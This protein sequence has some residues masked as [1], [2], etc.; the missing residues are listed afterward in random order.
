MGA[1]LGFG[2]R[3][4]GEPALRFSHLTAE[5]RVNPALEPGRLFPDLELTD[6]SGNRR[7]LSALAAGDPLV[8][9]CYRGWFCPKERAFFARLCQF[10]QELEVAYSRLVSVS[11]EPP[12]V[13]AAFRAGLDARWT[14]LSDADRT[15]LVQLDLQE[16]TDTVH[17]PYLPTVFT[18]YP[19]RTI[20]RIYNGYWFWGRPTM[21]ELRQDLRQISAAVR[22][23]W[24]G[25]QA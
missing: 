3:G 19:D 17:D 24:E 6:H 16:S 9:H 1:A 23:D 2:E 21:E 11:V 4:S 7:T 20:H 22:D 8:V 12:E 25:P 13:Q 18:L 15:A 5:E 10:Q 14:F